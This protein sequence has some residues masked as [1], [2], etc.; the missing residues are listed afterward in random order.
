MT[1]IKRIQIK[2]F[3]SIK[4]LDVDTNYLTLFVGQNDAG[5]SNILRALNLFFNDETNPKTELFFE[6]DN[7]VLNKPTK[8]V[9]QIEI[10]I[11]IELP[12]NYQETNGHRIVW[13]KKWRS[14]GVVAD[15]YNGVR[16]SKNKRGNDV[17]ES[18]DVPAK[19]NVHTLL[20]NIH[21][22]Y[23]PAI[24]DAGY[25]ELLR[26]SIYQLISDVAASTFKASSQ[27]FETSI[28]N[29]LTEL[30]TALNEM[31]GYQTNLALPKDLT[32][33]FEKLDFLGGEHTISLN[34]RGDGIKARHIPVILKFLAERKKET[35]TK[36]SQPFT[37]IWGYEEPENNVEM[38]RCFEMA[39]EFWSYIYDDTA[40]IF[41]T[42]H[43]P[44]FYGLVNKNTE[45]EEYVNLHHVYLQKIEEG[46]Q[47]AK[48]T[49]E[50]DDTMG[51]TRLIA[52][53]LNDEKINWEKRRDAKDVAEKVA[54]EAVLPI[55]VEGESD[56]LILKQAFEVYAPHVS[57]RVNVMTFPRAGTEFVKN[58]LVAWERMMKNRP[59]TEKKKAFG[60]FDNDQAGIDAEKALKT[61]VKI[62]KKKTPFDYA[63]LESPECLKRLFSEVEMNFPIT[64]ESYYPIKVWQH[65]ISNGWVTESTVANVATPDQINDMINNGVQLEQYLGKE[66]HPA[67]NHEFDTG[68]KVGA[69]KYALRKHRDETLSGF[70]GL[71]KTIAEYLFHEEEHPWQENAAE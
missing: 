20:R 12:P 31:L 66:Y 69:A 30:T 39:D 23:V 54:R 53:L 33:I 40:Q 32:H 29:Q 59:N 44:V 50:I 61:E 18:I 27:N 46:T 57:E 28:S 41:V 9:P 37:F 17:R 45:E 3:R 24:R 38:S 64:L 63:I 16:I 56:Q 47:I 6:E 60:I 5:K 36:G 15:D 4:S 8:R 22:V 2:N 25:F 49:S 21:F 10:T 26:G 14:H 7:Y 11:E 1:T 19:S 67:I 68:F 65:A 71:V 70:E 34:N 48:D 52:P 42:T 55:F 58:H 51:I 13:S 35:Q 43:S 62:N